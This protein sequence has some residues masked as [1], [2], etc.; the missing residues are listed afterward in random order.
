MKQGA[1]LHSVPESQT[2]LMGFPANRAAKATINVRVEW[3][4]VKRGCQFRKIN[5]QN[6]PTVQLTY[7]RIEAWRLIQRSK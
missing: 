5:S 6:N 1:L 7:H 4:K 2:L 3:V